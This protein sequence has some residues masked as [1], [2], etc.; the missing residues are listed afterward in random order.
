VTEYGNL[1]TQIELPVYWE[2]TSPFS[3][4]YTINFDTTSTNII[5]SANF[6]IRSIP[7]IRDLMVDVTSS[8]SEMGFNMNYW[9][10]Y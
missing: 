5:D 4:D 2:V 6:G 10:H 3:G 7:G 9:I 8:P 1:H